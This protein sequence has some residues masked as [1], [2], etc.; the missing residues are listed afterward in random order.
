MISFRPLQGQPSNED[1][2]AQHYD[3]LMRQALRWTGCDRALAEDL[4]H[5][6]FLQF[7]ELEAKLQVPEQTLGYLFRMLRNLSISRI[8]RANSLPMEELSLIDYDTAE[9]S[10]AQADRRALLQA[11][12]V[13]QRTCL[14]ACERKSSSASASVLILRFFHGYYPSEI[15]SICNRS[16]SSVDNFLALAR[17]EAKLANERPGFLRAMDAQCAHALQTDHTLSEDVLRDLSEMIFQHVE[18]PCLTLTQLDDRYGSPHVSPLTA[19][20]L[21]HLV[22]C[23]ACLDR[24]N[25][26]L[27]LPRLL[28]RY[29]PDTA[30]RISGSKKGPVSVKKTEAARF[31]DKSR[32]R[33]HQMREHRPAHLQ[34]AVNGRVKASHSVT[35]AISKLDVRVPPARSASFIE[36]LSEQ[37]VCLLYLPIDHGVEPVDQQ[38]CVNMS[39]NRRLLVAV[40][41][42]LQSFRVSVTYTDPSIDAGLVRHRPEE[43]L[44]E[45]G[46]IEQQ[47]HAS[48]IRP[49]YGLRFLAST[50]YQNFLSVL[51]K[52]PTRGSIPMSPTLAT[53]AILAVAS[54]ACLISWMQEP[55]LISPDTLLHKAAMWDADVKPGV[56]YQSL[57]VTTPS[58]SFDLHLY[59]DA[60]GIRKRRSG[61]L[62]GGSNTFDDQLRLAGVDPGAPLSAGLYQDWHDRQRVRADRVSKAGQRFLKLTTTTPSG[63]V[64]EASLVVRASDF[65]PVE[66][67]IEMREPA[68]KIE[69]AELNY[70]MLPWDKETEALFEPEEVGAG[71][72]PLRPTHTTP[73]PHLPPV[74][75]EAQLDEAELSAR[76]VLNR[77]HADNGERVNLVRGASGIRIIG[78]VET[79][80]RKRELES[81]LRRLSNVHPS[82]LTYREMEQQLAPAAA[83]SVT[84]APVT[85]QPTPLQGYL[86]ARRWSQQRIGEF[87]FELSRNAELINRECKAINELLGAFASGKALSVKADTALAELLSQHRDTLLE[88]VRFE[89]EA[90]S[91]AREQPGAEQGPV[92]P[93]ATLQ[94]L[95]TRNVDLARELTSA[96]GSSAPGNSAAPETLVALA[97]TVNSLHTAVL[98]LNV[99]EIAQ[100][101]LFTAANAP[102]STRNE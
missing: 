73:L 91:T 2:F 46:G 71:E 88:L 13:L 17:K 12:Y 64:A 29:P 97:A 92:S 74:L 83:G 100:G 37:N 62:N 99:A 33:S 10:L 84:L 47:K 90:L 85:S 94:A 70:Q 67:T 38:V 82:L 101:A 48:L 52:I 98:S 65:H 20:E 93:T 51:A 34:V 31:I 60:R 30:G 40:N 43:P 25:E 7:V 23:K 14:Y 41:Y 58:R 72:R 78:V 9:L 54:I 68:G 69:I 63:P 79:E 22:S 49:L 96:S 102:K 44:P 61:N 27:G 89:E 32:R 28:D 4:L 59:R 8:R 35:A 76:L 81:Q 6:V 19:A 53:S 11:R 3:A 16:R 95:A 45:V 50:F 75:G 86:E 55:P 56:I 26:R 42:E 24:A 15:V 18:G 80:E 77:L 57:H 5:D 36:I 87:S 66:R 1:L 21:S 39:D